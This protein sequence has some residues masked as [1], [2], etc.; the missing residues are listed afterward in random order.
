[1]DSKT[2]VIVTWT[3]KGMTIS[4]AHDKDEAEAML[5]IEADELDTLIFE[6][7]RASLLRDAW[8]RTGLQLTA[9]AQYL[10]LDDVI[11]YLRKIDI[12]PKIAAAIILGELDKVR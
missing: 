10:A 3:V 1:M 9:N 4:K 2:V 8:S 11:L 5:L 6:D 7:E 12:T